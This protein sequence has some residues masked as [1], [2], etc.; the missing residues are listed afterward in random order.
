MNATTTSF[1][2]VDLLKN[3]GYAYCNIHD[4][5]EVAAGHI[6]SWLA[7]APPIPA[8]LASVAP[9]LGRRTT[10][11]EALREMADLLDQLPEPELPDE[12][13]FREWLKQAPF[14]NQNEYVTQGEDYLSGREVCDSASLRATLV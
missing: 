12:V 7:N 5:V 2:T 13:M 10:V 1:T 14:D 3:I 4:C 11:C 9:V 8:R 6:E